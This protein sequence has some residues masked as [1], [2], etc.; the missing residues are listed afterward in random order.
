LNKDDNIDQNKH[1]YFEPLIFLF[2]ADMI[3]SQ[4][5]LLRDNAREFYLHTVYTK[6]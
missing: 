3:S 6:L 1:S 4:Q 2:T 5:V